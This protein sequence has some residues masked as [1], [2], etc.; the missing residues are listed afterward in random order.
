MRLASSLALLA[1]AGVTS[2]AAAQGTPPTAGRG[3][4]APAMVLMIPGWPDG[5]QIPVRFTQAGEQVSPELRWTNVPAST[6]SFV[7]NMQDLD[8]AVQRGTETQPHWIV[9]SIPKTATGLPE[10]MKPG[11]EQP[12]GTRQI[13]ATA[14]QYRGP[15]APASGPLHHYAFEVYALDTKID[16]S[17]AT[18]ATPIASALDT[19]TAVLRAMQGHVIGKAVYVGLFHR[20]Q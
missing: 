13:S 11:A 5:T 20:P 10:G 15:G 6:E 3:P 18:G 14:P 1:L 9:W 12:D 17:P 16:V 8:V 7:V 2:T 19:R 4:A